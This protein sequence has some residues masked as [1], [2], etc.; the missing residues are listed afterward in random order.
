MRWRACQVRVLS[1]DR[2]CGGSLRIAFR[3]WVEVVMRAEYPG[4]SGE[5]GCGHRDKGKRLGGIGIAFVDITILCHGSRLVLILG[6]IKRGTG[7][8]LTFACTAYDRPACLLRH[9]YP[10]TRMNVRAQLPISYTHVLNPNRTYRQPHSSFP[11]PIEHPI[12]THH[13]HPTQRPYSLAF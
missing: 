5:Q 8:S 11:L 2:T 3:H 1:W 13:L 4:V 10:I 9:T 7:P 12:T 6:I